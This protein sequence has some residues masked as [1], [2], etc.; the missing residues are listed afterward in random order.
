M[1]H[2][3]PDTMASVTRDLYERVAYHKA[4]FGAGA[5][6]RR[7]PE[8]GIRLMPEGEVLAALEADYKDMQPMFFAQPA[9][10]PFADVL[11]ELRALEATLRAL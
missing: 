6:V 4:V 7:A 3:H 11:A 2:R 10:P 9:A 5:A 8:D 1:M